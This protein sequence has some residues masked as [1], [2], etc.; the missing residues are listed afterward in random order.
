MKRFSYFS[1]CLSILTMFCA[2]AWAQIITDQND[3]QIYKMELPRNYDGKVRNSFYYMKDDG[4]F[5]DD[6]K[7]DEA[8]YIF[9]QC[10]T[11][12]IQR[13]YFDCACVSG[14]FRQARDS[15]DLVPQGQIVSE[16]FNDDD[17]PCVNTVGIAGNSYNKCLS[18]S[19]SYRQYETSESNQ[20]YCQ[21]VANDFAQKFAAKPSLNLRHIEKSQ[22]RSMVDCNKKL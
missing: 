4:I 8:M 5:S 11:N 16:I 3:T 15:E 1:L 20:K 7:D 13:I 12:F 18:Y 6:E 9:Q 14:L 21:C 2:S 10:N 19:K 17:T 22:A